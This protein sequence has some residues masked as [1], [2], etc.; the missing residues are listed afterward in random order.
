MVI[1]MYGIRYNTQDDFSIAKGL[2]PGR[3]YVHFPDKRRFSI[4]Y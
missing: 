4:G 1:S 3:V 2:P